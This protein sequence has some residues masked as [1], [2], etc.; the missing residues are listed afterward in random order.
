MGTTKTTYRVQGIPVDASPDDIKM[1][2]SQ[3]LGEDASRLDPTIHSLA[4]DPYKPPNSSTNVATV[5]FK[6]TPKTLKDSDRLTADVTW[7]SKT[8]Y[9]TVDSSFGGFTPLN[10]AKTKLGSRMD[11]IAV[12][13][14][15]SHPFG[16]WK[17]RGGTFMWLRDEVAKTTEKARVLLYGYDTTLANSESFQDVGDIAQRLSSDLNAMRSGRTTSWVPTPIVFVAHSLG[18]LVVKE[19]IYKMSEHYPDDFLSIYGLLL[20]GVPNLGIKTEYW[21]PIVDTKP[22]RN[23]I[24]S[25]APDAFYLRNLQVNFTKVFCFPGARVTSVFETKKSATAKEESPGQWKLTGPP[26]ILVTRTSAT[27]HYSDRVQHKHIAFNQNHSDL[28][29]FGSNYDENYRAIEPFFKECYDDALEVIHKR[30]NSEALNPKYTVNSTGRSRATCPSCSKTCM[31]QVKLL[32][33]LKERGNDICYQ[34]ALRVAVQRGRMGITSLL[35]IGNER[36]NAKDETAST[37]LHYAAAH[38]RLDI[39]Q[40]LLDRG[41]SIEARDCN[42]YTP[43]NTA[44]HYGKTDSVKLLVNRGANIETRTKE[45]Q[46]PLMLAAWN[47]RIDVVRCLLEQG[48]DTEARNYYGLTPLTGVTYDGRADIVGLL[49]D[50]GAYIESQ[51]DSGKTPLAWAVEGNNVDVVKLLRSRGAGKIIWDATAGAR[52]Y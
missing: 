19:A 15:S 20:F 40:L 42:G 48:A 51:D 44:A 16:S 12:S 27:G 13:G 49:V 6:H 41:A 29:K 33:H 36:I 8:H 28:P 30:F 18:G 7:D 35:L 25:L 4:S 3:A 38:E 39:V 37:L 34:D 47:D 5:T 17:A 9:I 11:V 46:T 1:I 43:L 50:G 2:I 14:L 23:L 31:S 24:D 26:D 32:Q 45:G 10:D 52:Y 21:M 22:N